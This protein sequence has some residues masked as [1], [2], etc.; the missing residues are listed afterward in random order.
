MYPLI[1]R[2]GDWALPS[3]SVFL[4]L[5]FIAF[6]GVFCFQLRKLKLPLEP[7]VNFSFA[8]L[9]VSL[10]GGR[11]LFFIVE[12]DRFH[13]SGLSFWHFWEGGIVFYGGLLFALP[14]SWIFLPKLYSHSSW[15]RTLGLRFMAPAIC[16][17]HAIG[18][19]GCFLN[20]CCYGGFC[21]FPWSV[22]Y[23]S[24]YSAAPT[25]VPLHPVQIYEALFLFIFGLFLIHRN[26]NPTRFR[27]TF[28]GS[29]V[30]Y[31]LGYGTF[32]FFNEFFRADPYRGFWGIFSTSQWISVGVIGLGAYL[33]IKRRNFPFDFLSRDDFKASNESS[34]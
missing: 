21:S 19:I 32:R 18:R 17:G 23:R 5:G 14:F 30:L 1:F 10:F 13:A 12:G 28:P 16:L 26:L 7:A 22:V 31:L 34:S 11:L 6:L 33:L 25:G 24:P 8:G 15:N 29:D 3:Y 20:G 27:K 4:G 9:L 2:M